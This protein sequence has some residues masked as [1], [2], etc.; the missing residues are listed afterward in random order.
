MFD[1]IL[2][3]MGEVIWYV[4]IHNGKV[5]VRERF[6]EFL[7]LNRK[8]TADNFKNLESDGLDIM[9][10]SAQCYDNVASMAGIQGGLQEIL[11][12]KNKKDIFN[13]CEDH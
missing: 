2:D 4:K 6:Y 10:C 5:G 12:R 13:G 1:N 9:M 8:T 3:K 7:L 11:K